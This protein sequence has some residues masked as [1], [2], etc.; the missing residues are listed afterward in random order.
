MKSLN[1]TFSF[2]NQP[3]KPKWKN[4]L[5]QAWK[6]RI[7]E[8]HC[9]NCASKSHLERRKGSSAT[10][11][12]FSLLF[13][14]F[15]LS[16]FFHRLAAK[17]LISHAQ[18]ILLCGQFWVISLAAWFDLDFQM[19]SP[20]QKR[21]QFKAVNCTFS[22]WICPKFLCQQ[23]MRLSPFQPIPNAIPRNASLQK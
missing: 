3:N 13:R 7:V 5:R 18:I 15:F 1:H 22:Y 21:L 9:I 2:K 16:S 8:L 10:F 19:V 17:P 6:L 12:T 4:T 20:P 14:I 11:R 23:S